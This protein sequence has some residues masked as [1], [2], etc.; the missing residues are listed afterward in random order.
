MHGV[1]NTLQKHERALQTPTY[2]R[3]HYR[4]AY[5]QGPELEFF[6]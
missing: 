2:L 6:A 5:C 1:V 3:N 4:H